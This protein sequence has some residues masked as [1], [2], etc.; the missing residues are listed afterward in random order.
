M[1]AKEE[2]IKAKEEEKLQKLAAK[3]Q[4]KNVI[5]S[6]SQEQSGCT[7]VLKTGKNKGLPC[8]AKICNNGL[9][10][11]HFKMQTLVVPVPI[12]VVEIQEQNT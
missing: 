8:G 4:C 5:V 11:R 12:P 7:Q 1:K 9:C 6:S 10:S 3:M 2:K